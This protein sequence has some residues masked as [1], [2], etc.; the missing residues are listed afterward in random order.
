M[1]TFDCA[2]SN[3]TLAVRFL[4]RKVRTCRSCIQSLAFVADPNPVPVPIGIGRSAAS[5]RLL[6]VGEHRCPLFGVRVCYK[7][8]SFA[9]VVW[10]EVLILLVFVLVEDPP[11]ANGFKGIQGRSAFGRV[12][13]PLVFSSA[14][15]L[16]RRR[17]RGRMLGKS[18]GFRE[19]YS[20]RHAF[21]GRVLNRRL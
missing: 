4:R 2:H 15:L 13:D 21:L 12:D 8:P 9:A 7:D 11:F 19:G 17:V 18:F 10:P 20:R 16:G 3:A 6:Y 5:C 1:A 14:R